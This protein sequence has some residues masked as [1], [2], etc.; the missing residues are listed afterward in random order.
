MSISFGANVMIG[1]RAS[2]VRTVV[3]TEVVE[4]R[5]NPKTGKPVA[6]ETIRTERVSLFGREVDPTVHP[7]MWPWSVL[8]G[9]GLE[10]YARMF[11][12]GDFRYVIIGLMPPKN[13]GDIS[14]A[15]IV[16]GPTREKVKAALAALNCKVEPQMFLV[17]YAE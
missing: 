16:E 15:P 1:V 17:T 5:F 14:L 7:S 2:D 11:G 12:R 4:P 8:E 9:T 13:D 6:P 3:V 10:V